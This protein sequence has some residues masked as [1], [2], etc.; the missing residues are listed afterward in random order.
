MAI[1]YWWTHSLFHCECHFAAPRSCKSQPF[2]SAGYIVLICIRFNWLCAY[3]F[4]FKASK[5]WEENIRA[6]LQRV[7]HSCLSARM[8]LHLREA[9]TF[10]IIDVPPRLST[11]SYFAGGDQDSI[12][13]NLEFAIWRLYELKS[14]DTESFVI[15]VC[16]VLYMRTQERGS[17]SGTRDMQ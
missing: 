4:V 5:F 2:A 8:I 6:R 16:R 3:Y 11:I 13:D 1:K 12:A 10:P 14:S 7:L 17:N 9:S 15:Y